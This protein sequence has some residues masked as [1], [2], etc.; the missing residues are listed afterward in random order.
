MDRVNIL[1]YLLCFIINFKRYNME[2][3]LFIY[4]KYTDLYFY[5]YNLLEKYPKAEKFALVIQ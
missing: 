5:A 3:N 1:N 4:K 2:N